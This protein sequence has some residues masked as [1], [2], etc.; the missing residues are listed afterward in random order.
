MRKGKIASQASHASLDAVWNNGFFTTLGE[1]IGECLCIPI[2]PRNEAWIKGS[3]TKICVYVN[4]EAE[5]LEVYEKAFAAGIDVSLIKDKGLTE[6][7]GVA[8]Y[9]A[10]G[11]G[12]DSSEVI[13]VI[14]GSLPLL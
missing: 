5:L 7:G 13:D 10:V 14:T 8:T 1:G 11:L 2:T 9:T 4:S 12:P 3:F 6:F